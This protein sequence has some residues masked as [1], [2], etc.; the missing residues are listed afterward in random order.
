MMRRLVTG[1]M[2]L[3]VI[4]FLV[5]P[6]SAQEQSGTVTISSTAIAAGIGVSWGDGQLVLN[7]GSTHSFSV[8]G[9]SVVDIG[10]SSVSAAGK[11]YNLK[12]LEDFNG[13]YV[14]G[15]AGAVVGGGAGVSRMKNQNDVV[16]ELTSTQAGV[17]FTLA[18]AGVTL[19]LK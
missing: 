7:D 8:D 2:S 14:A 18:P 12:K 15:E 17:R 19:Q 4:A 9:L 1:L 13:T 10:I 5:A 3:A 11:I 6:A 16:I